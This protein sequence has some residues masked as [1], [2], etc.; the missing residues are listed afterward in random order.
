MLVLVSLKMG[1]TLDV[2]GILGW[3]CVEA[4]AWLVNSS[5]GMFPSSSQAD[6]AVGHVSPW[7]VGSWYPCLSP[8]VGQVGNSCMLARCS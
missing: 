7:L 2:S 1:P 5:L 3:P 6:P 8:L 4:F